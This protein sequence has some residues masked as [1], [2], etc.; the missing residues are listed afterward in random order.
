M[1]HYPAVADAEGVSAIN[2]D[3]LP[4]GIRELVR[5]LGFSAALRLIERRG[6]LPLRV[7]KRVDWSAPNPRALALLDDVGDA[8]AVARLV[9]YAG[10]STIDY[11]P[12]YDAVARQLRHAQVCALRRRGLSVEDIALKTGYSARRVFGILE[13]ESAP[14]RVAQRDLFDAPAA[15]DVPAPAS[16]PVPFAR[17]HSELAALLGVVNTAIERATDEAAKLASAVSQGGRHD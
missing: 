12:K 16:R 7:P 4:A 15:P 11:L 9:D 8:A 3:R 13:A 14:G 6:G 2:L 17:G 1:R 10:G 5:V